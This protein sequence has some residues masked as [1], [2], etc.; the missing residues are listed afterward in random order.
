MLA[1]KLCDYPIGGDLT[2]DSALCND[3]ATNII[4]DLDYCP[5]HSK[6]HEF[7]IIYAFQYEKEGSGI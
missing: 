2:C 1:E 6:T 7:N 5:E 4:G 3:C